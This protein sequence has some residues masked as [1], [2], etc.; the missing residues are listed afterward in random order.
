[1]NIWLRPTNETRDKLVQLFLNDG[2]APENINSL[3]ELN[4]S[5]AHTFY[6]GTPPKRIDFLTFI[7]GVDFDE[8][9]EQKRLLPLENYQIPV[10]HLNH[11]ILSKM[12]NDR[13][14]DK[15]DIEELQ[16]IQAIKKS[17]RSEED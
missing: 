8:A 15:A 13:I 10:L 3:K 2:F 14:R 6:M 16:K 11:L 9:W 4:F 17:R 1:M 12:S 7:S 5:E